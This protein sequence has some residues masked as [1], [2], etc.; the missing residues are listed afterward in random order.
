[1]RVLLLSLG[2]AFLYVVFGKFG[3]MQAVSPGIA[4][5][6]FLPAGIALAAVYVGGLSQI[7]AV[8]VGALI[9]H[10]WIADGLGQLPDAIGYVS[11]LFIALASSLQAGLGSWLLKK[12]IGYPM[13]LDRI[14]EIVRFSLLTP[15]ICLVSSSLSS[16]S[17]LALGVF[18]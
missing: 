5:P 3:A 15:V 2:V 17:L 4:L 18:N 16:T 7:P 6:I 8:F 9:T 11:A 13:R 14:G 10:L 12:A 1:M